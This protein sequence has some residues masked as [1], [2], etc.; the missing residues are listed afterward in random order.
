MSQFIKSSA[1]H[2]ALRKSDSDARAAVKSERNRISGFTE[3]E[4]AAAKWSSNKLVEAKDNLA[5]KTNSEVRNP[6]RTASKGSGQ[7][8]GTSKDVHRQRSVQNA[9]IEVLHAEEGKQGK[10]NKK[11]KKNEK[12]KKEKKMRKDDKDA[13]KLEK[14]ARKLA[15]KMRKEEKHLRRQERLEKTV[16]GQDHGTA[17]SLAIDQL[18]EGARLHA[19]ADSEQLPKQ[20]Q[21]EG[22][23]PKKKLKSTEDSDGSSSSSSSRTYKPTYQMMADVVEEV[24]P[25][26][27]APCR[28]LEEYCE[29]LP[30]EPRNPLNQ[31]HNMEAYKLHSAARS[32]RIASGPEDK[33]DKE[34]FWDHL[35]FLRRSRSPDRTR[36]KGAMWP[37]RA[38]AWK[39]RAGGAYLPPTDE[40]PNPG[41]KPQGKMLWGD[42]LSRTP[43]P[44]LARYAYPED[45]KQRVAEIR[46]NRRSP[47]YNPEPRG[48]SKSSSPEKGKQTEEQKNIRKLLREKRKEAE[49]KS[50]SR[51]L[52]RKRSKKRKKSRQGKSHSRSQSQP[53]KKKKNIKKLKKSRTPSPSPAER[54]SPDY[55]VELVS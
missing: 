40:A 37:T 19:G 3:A 17:G 51:S 46:P 20:V 29:A 50:R 48:G 47:S 52:S 15:K 27:P 45:F 35:P 33:E 5:R 25:P 10:E 55:G 49:K 18:I 21:P 11:E 38:G 41:S 32:R 24:H 43:S 1:E 2:T 34:E 14:G 9:V 30:P 16:D 13:R 7:T 8:H 42:N 31:A 22:L 36:T 6:S 4:L 53:S 39:S 54:A 12:D 23:A 26:A 28:S 44:E